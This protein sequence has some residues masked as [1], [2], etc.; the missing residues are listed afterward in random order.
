MTSWTNKGLGAAT[1]IYERRGFQLIDE[2]PVTS[3]G[4]GVIGQT[5]EVS[6]GIYQ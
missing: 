1:G 5:W 6:L 2:S 3:Y 4:D